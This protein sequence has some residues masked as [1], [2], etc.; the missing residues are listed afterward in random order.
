M[1]MPKDPNAFPTERMVFEAAIAN[2]GA[3]YTLDSPKRATY[4]RH[5]MNRFRALMSGLGNSRYADFTLRVDE[6]TVI[7]EPSVLTGN[8]T[9]LSGDVISNVPP[10][11]SIPDFSV[12][13]ISED[14][15]IKGLFDE[16]TQPGSTEE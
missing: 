10:P 2:D 6:A 16:I 8:L 7:V 4:F 5:R 15:L 12:V 11:I 3:K 9:S 1:P 13:Q 14:D